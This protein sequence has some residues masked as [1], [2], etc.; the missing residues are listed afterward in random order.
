MLFVFT[1]KT[2]M[3]KNVENQKWLY[4]DHLLNGIPSN[5]FC[6]KNGAI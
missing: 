3:L 2:G 6:G 4:V 1:V 5:D